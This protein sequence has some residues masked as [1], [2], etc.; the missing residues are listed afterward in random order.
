[1]RK[2]KDGVIGVQAWII[3]HNNN[4]FNSEM[5]RVDAVVLKKEGNDTHDCSHL[6]LKVLLV[7]LSTRETTLN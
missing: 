6:F 7:F 1:M 2:L 5:I 3:V 4:L